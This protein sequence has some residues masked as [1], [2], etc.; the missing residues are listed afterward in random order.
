MSTIYDRSAQD[1]GNIVNLEHVNTRVPDQQLATTFYVMGLGLTRDPYQQTGTTNMWMNA[2]RAQFHLPTG[3]P[4]VVRGHT[5]LV[6]EGR[7]ALLE[8]LANVAPA[9]SDTRFAVREHNDHV[10]VVCERAG[11]ARTVRA[12]ASRR[13][14]CSGSG[15]STTRW[16]SSAWRSRPS[17]APTARPERWPS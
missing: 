6:I 5:G 14:M 3:A 12:R 1:V 10:D 7:D 9:L 2:G 15:S 4:Q 8:R 13:A 17:P 16:S 11:E